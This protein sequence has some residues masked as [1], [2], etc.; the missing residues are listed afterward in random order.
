MIP[1]KSLVR[2]Y[3]PVDFKITDWSRLK[4]YYEEL[5]SR[6]IRSVSDLMKWLKDRSE[7]DSIVSEDL[8]WRYIRM[9]CDTSVADYQEQFN[10]FINEIEPMTAPFANEL[11][12]KYFD[13]EFREQLKGKEFLLLTRNIGKEI[14]IFREEN[15]PVFTEIQTEQKTYGA[16]IGA[17]TVEV[18]GQEITLPRASDYLQNTDR[19]IRE[20][21]YR[22]IQKRRLQDK[23]KLDTLYSKLIGLRHQVAVNAGFANF[24]DYMF[25]A[26]GRFDYSVK[27]CAD[28]HASVQEFVVPLIGDIAK[29]RK[30]SL[31]LEDLKPWDLSV[32][33]QLKSPLKP[34]VDGNDLLEKTIQCF[35]RLDPFLGN[36][37]KE[38][39]SMKHLDLESKKGKAPGGYNYPLYESGYPFIF[40]NATSNFRDMITLLH[41]GGHAVH[42]ILTKDLD[43]VEFKSL[44]SEVAEL[45]SM[46]ME[47]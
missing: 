26:L 39:R 17:M 21:V 29:E 42:S 24:R 15:I 46:S 7:I 22:K 14:Q 20:E 41:E 30:A 43:V 12:K 25:T 18:N 38:M 28:F 11:N 8:A 45:A 32:D 35:D 34:F 40:M 47:L 5:T 37:L 23:D 31:K 33:R 4:P 3:V 9:T 27:D 2:H 10:F 19:N 44:P 13:S 1:T 16:T 36:C 6:E